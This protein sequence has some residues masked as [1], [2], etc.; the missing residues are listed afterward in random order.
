MLNNNKFLILYKFDGEKNFEFCKTEKDVI[1]FISNLK[2]K[3]RDGFEWY[4][5]ETE[6]Y[7]MN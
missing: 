3:Y 5:L 2:N 1:V 4:V 6:N 7:T